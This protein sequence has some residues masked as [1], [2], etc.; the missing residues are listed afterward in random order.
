MW[1][2]G[3][4]AREKGVACVFPAAQYSLL[5]VCLASLYEVAGGPEKVKVQ[6][7]PCWTR[8]AAMQEVLPWDWLK[9]RTASALDHT[10]P[11]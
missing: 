11:H 10:L 7:Q 2:G 3:G 4:V 5:P 9:A 6:G 1:W 8:A